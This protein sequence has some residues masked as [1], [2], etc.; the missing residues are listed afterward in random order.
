MAVTQRSFTILDAQFPLPM[1]YTSVRGVLKATVIQENLLVKPLSQ[2]LN[3]S[4][5]DREVDTRK[6]NQDK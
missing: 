5:E 3:P 4:T 6:I 1:R 2:D